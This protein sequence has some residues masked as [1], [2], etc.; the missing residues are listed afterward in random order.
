MSSL[1]RRADLPEAVTDAVKEVIDLNWDETQRPHA[2]RMA[3]LIG[4]APPHGMSGLTYRDNFPNGKTTSMSC[5]A[6]IMLL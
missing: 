2:V 1:D 5:Y 6:L 3:V 4:D